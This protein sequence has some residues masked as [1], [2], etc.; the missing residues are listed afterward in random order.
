MTVVHR[1]KFPSDSESFS[2]SISQRNDSAERHDI[3]HHPKLRHHLVFSQ[4]K[5]QKD[6]ESATSDSESVILE[7]DINA[8]ETMTTMLALI[9]N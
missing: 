2:F 8:L 3:L 9:L 7:E 4:Q 6:S 5:D 1:F